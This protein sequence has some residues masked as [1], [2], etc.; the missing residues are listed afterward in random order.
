MSDDQLNEVI[1][2]NRVS[3]AYGPTLALRDVSMV[4]R[5][6]EARAVVG[7]NG[8][9]KSTLMGVL[10]GLVHPDT[11]S[12]RIGEEDSAA[13]GAPIGCVYQR[14]TLVPAAT[15]AE[16]VALGRYPRGP[17]GLISWR[18][19]R[20][21]ARERLREWHCEQLA[22]TPVEELEPLERK[23][24]EI[25]RVLAL[26]SR[27]LLL[28]EPTPGL[29]AD[30][31]ARLF[32]HI[33][34]A[35]ERGVTLVY[36]SH[37]LQEIFDVCDSVTILRDGAVVTTEGLDALTVSD[38]VAGMVG[39]HLGAAPEVV[40]VRRDPAPQAAPARDGAVV[41]EARGLACAPKVTR[42]DLT[43]RAGERV[44]V[45][46]L[47]GSGAIQVAEMLAGARAPDA[48]EA[49]VNGRA[50]PFGAVRRAIRAGIGFTPQDRH[51]SGFVPGL[52]VAENTTLPIVQPARQPPP[53]HPAGRPRSLLPSLGGGV[54]HQGLG[55]Q[56]GGGGAQ[57]RQP[58]EGRARAVDGGRSEGARADR[59]DRRR[60]RRG[61]GVD[62]RLD[63]AARRRRPGRP[64]RLVGR[65]RPRDLR[66]R[67]RHVPRIR[68]RRVAP[69]NH[70]P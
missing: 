30:A 15:A 31:T 60:Q 6:G 24:V 40:A 51:T 3:K 66:P 52:S 18:A 63:R 53:P 36:V 35:R 50:L 21:E 55:A 61:E 12:V 20:D 57:R 26:G 62:L 39:S 69:T 34:R 19:V 9:G 64:D 67:A 58:A 33:A 11:G 27:I 65:D 29:D 47:D 43:L 16:N 23:I 28:D 70:R 46:G 1:S 45:A 48:G 10:T 38:L 17:L 37:H 2:V 49:T 25:C 44:G 68:G 7:R 41:L 4:V 13:D 32:E 5:A 42:F 56:P 22:D 59:S 8:A 54:E 14:S